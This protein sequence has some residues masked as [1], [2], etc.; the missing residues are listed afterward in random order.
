MAKIDDAVAKAEQE[1]WRQ[2]HTDIDRALRM[3]TVASME[4]AVSYPDKPD[5]QVIKDRVTIVKQICE[6]FK[7]SL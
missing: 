1:I 5:Q 7:Y 3:L 2:Q 4:F 6:N